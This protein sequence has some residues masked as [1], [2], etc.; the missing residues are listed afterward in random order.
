MCTN[1]ISRDKSPALILDHLAYTPSTEPT[2]HVNALSS[3]GL[4]S[5]SARDPARKCLFIR[6]EI[7]RRIRSTAE[8]EASPRGEQLE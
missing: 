3:K 8:G 1:Y 7:G 2:K 6:D 4:L 5:V